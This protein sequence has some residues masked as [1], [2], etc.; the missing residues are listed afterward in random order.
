[1]WS[2]WS[3]ITHP[4]SP[5]QTLLLSSGLNSLILKSGLIFLPRLEPNIL[6]SQQNIM[7]VCDVMQFIF[8][9]L[10]TVISLLSYTVIMFF[11]KNTLKFIRKKNKFTIYKE[12]GYTV[13]G[14]TWH[15]MQ[16]FSKI[17]PYFL[18]FGIKHYEL[19]IIQFTDNLLTFQ[20]VISGKSISNNTKIYREKMHHFCHECTII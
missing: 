15:S 6:S 13:N 18:F 9:H 8:A 2:L 10:S 12:N 20:G 4:A 14:L 1:M 11:K 7:K 16:F 19:W 17:L 3:R 5:T